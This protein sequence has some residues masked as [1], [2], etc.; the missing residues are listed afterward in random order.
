MQ[1]VRKFHVTKREALEQVLLVST[2]AT[3]FCYEQGFIFLCTSALLNSN[4]KMCINK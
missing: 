3:F 1:L 2:Y 4:L